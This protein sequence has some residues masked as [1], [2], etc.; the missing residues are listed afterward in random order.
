MFIV[1][2]KQTRL[3]RNV[4]KLADFFP[5]FFFV[6]GFAWDARTFGGEVS[7]IDL[8]ILITY[9]L[10]SAL[11]LY[12]LSQYFA[13]NMQNY[14]KWFKKALSTNW[15]YFVLQFL[16]GTL[17]N[18]LFVL[19][20]KSTGHLLA[21]LMTFC[22]GV[23]LVASE[24]F[25]DKLRE[26]TL[27]W[28]LFSFC[29]MMLFNFLIP[30]LIGSI[31]PAWFYISTVLGTGLAYLLYIK[32]PNHLG[33]IKPVWYIAT[34][35]MLAYAFDV[36]PPVPLVK[37]DIAVGY[38]LNKVNGNYQLSQPPS[39]WWVFWRKTSDDL[40]V[41]S[42]QRVYCFS[43]VFAPEG[44]KTRLYHLWQYYDQTKGWQTKS[45]VGFTLSGGREGGFRGY[46]F[47]QNL[48][49]GEWRVKVVTEYDKTV[50]VQKFTIASE[51]CNLPPI[52]QV[53]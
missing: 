3:Y 36:I 5:A 33:S 21:W 50:A 40:Q 7:A 15:P 46:T 31:N 34:L 2:I 23:I 51:Q 38:A 16:L 20:F 14:P 49:A 6:L 45:R 27:S 25:K 43:S 32:T 11:I 18:V 17:L 30:F 13:D 35:L 47:M 42:G 22:I 9:L 37:R 24:H 26:F 29:T 12:F 53:Y 39:S 52:V 8:F 48:Q 4:L 44:L 10:I 19:Y 28:A 41:V 1:R